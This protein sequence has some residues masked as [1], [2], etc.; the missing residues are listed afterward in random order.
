VPNH[1]KNSGKKIAVF[2]GRPKNSGGEPD[3]V[4]M[5]LEIGSRMEEKGGGQS[6]CH[7]PASPQLPPICVRLA[8]ASGE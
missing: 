8:L 7:R 1:T 6:G 5:A 2:N 3:A 4:T